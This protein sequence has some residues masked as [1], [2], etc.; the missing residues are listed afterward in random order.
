[1]FSGL[2]PKP[3]SK[4]TRWPKTYKLHID[5]LA[6]F[7]DFSVSLSLSFGENPRSFDELIASSS[8][9]RPFLNAV[10]PEMYAPIL[11]SLSAQW[12]LL[13]S[14][15]SDQDKIPTTLPLVFTGVNFHR[16]RHWYLRLPL[17]SLVCF[18]GY[19]NKTLNFDFKI[20][21]Q[22]VS[23]WIW[24][25]LWAIVILQWQSLLYIYIYINYFIHFFFKRRKPNPLIAV[26]GRGRD[27][28]PLWYQIVTPVTSNPEYSGPPTTSRIIKAHIPN[29]THPKSK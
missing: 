15:L 3:I 20:S 29:Y 23:W 4:P 5:S 24:Q 2:L 1:M 9:H 27:G 16:I 17:F 12:K 26:P 7:I 18:L 13:S 19:L 21:F 14:I 28:T 11:A 8:P 22:L 10:S 6:S 25:D